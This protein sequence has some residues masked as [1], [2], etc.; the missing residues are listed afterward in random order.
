MTRERV[1]STATIRIFRSEPSVSAEFQTRKRLERLIEQARIL[2]E[3]HV[4]QSPEG[5][6]TLIPAHS[7]GV[8]DFVMLG[9]STEDLEDFSGYLDKMAPL[10]DQLPTTLLIFSNG[11]ADLEA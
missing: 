8:A 11:E 4:L 9:L 10:L 2:A 7:T 3:V 5:P 6:Q 1:W